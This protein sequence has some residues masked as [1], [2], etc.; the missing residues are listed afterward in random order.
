MVKG[1]TISGHPKRDTPYM[2]ELEQS[3]A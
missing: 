2:A 3:F 1:L